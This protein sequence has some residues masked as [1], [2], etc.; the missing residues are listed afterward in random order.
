MASSIKNMLANFLEKPG[1][2]LTSNSAPRPVWHIKLISEWPKVVGA[3]HEQMRVEK[4]QGDLLTIGVFN[5][6]WL[7]ELYLLSPMLIKSINDYLQHPYV[8]QIKCKAAARKQVDDIHSARKQEK[9]ES[10]IVSRPLTSV[11]K[12]TLASVEDPELRS[13]L[14]TLLYVTH[15]NRVCV[16]KR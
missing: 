14:E 2:A 12:K 16:K 9:T 3:L 5:A 15:G 1:A 7:Q 8:K 10:R 13:M 4:I 6:S 11:E